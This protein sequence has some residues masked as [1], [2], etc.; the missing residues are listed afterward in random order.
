[1]VTTLTG[2][3]ENTIVP[4]S[5]ENQV[6]YSPP[7]AKQTLSLGNFSKIPPIIMEQMATVVSAGM[8]RNKKSFIIYGQTLNFR[9]YLHFPQKALSILKK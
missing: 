8:P 1:M 6:Y 2:I 5:T 3:A 4:C 7:C 9:C